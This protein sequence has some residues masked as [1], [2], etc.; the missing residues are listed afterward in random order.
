MEN[1]RCSAT[2]T[3]AALVVARRAAADIAGRCRRAEVA[4]LGQMHIGSQIAAAASAA[5]NAAHAA[6]GVG[7]ICNIC[8][9]CSAFVRVAIGAYLS[10]HRLRLRL[11][12]YWRCV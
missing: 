11:R 12:A 8:S 6:V 4:L 2:T 9:I 10:V 7:G 1:S 3:Q 5:A